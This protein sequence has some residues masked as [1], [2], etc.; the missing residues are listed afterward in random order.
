VEE[1]AEDQ[2]NLMEETHGDMRHIKWEDILSKCRN[3][4]I[5]EIE[6]GCTSTQMIYE[7]EDELLKKGKQLN[8]TL[9]KLNQSTQMNDELKDEF[10]KKGK[11]LND[12]IEELDQ[13]TQ[14]SY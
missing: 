12:T 11:Q 4:N 2:C 1:M 9:E 8:D 10:L 7:L 14:M 6:S 5:T 13:S 3:G